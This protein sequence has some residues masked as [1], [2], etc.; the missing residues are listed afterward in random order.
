MY[1]RRDERN[2]HGRDLTF[3]L[4]TPEDAFELLAFETAERAWF[5]QHIEARKEQ[6]Y[7]S[8]G[9]SQHIID[10]LA[11]NAQGRMSPLLIRHKGVLIGRANLRDIDGENASIGYRL[12]AC[13]CGQ[14]I[15]QKAL[16]HLMKEARCMYGLE[17]L[18][19]VVSVENQA[20]R[21]VLEK[22]GFDAVDKLPDHARV[23]DR[24][25]DCLVYRCVLRQEVECA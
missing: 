18:T 7:S 19:A 12:A 9:V 20:S 17:T 21:R 23:A 6:F 10:C 15:A 8:H 11:L 3:S 13:A 25:L 4:L 24:R 2:R 5:E 14:G 1:S 22:A 16:K